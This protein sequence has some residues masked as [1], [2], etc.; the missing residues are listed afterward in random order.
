MEEMVHR[1][2]AVA[3]GAPGRVLVG[4]MPFDA[5]HAA[6][7][8]A[9]HNAAA[10]LKA[11]MNAVKVE[12]GGRM[13]GLVAHLVERGIPVMGHL[14]LTP[15]FVNAFGGMRGHGRTGDDPRP[16]L[17]DTLAPQDPRASPLLLP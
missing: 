5:Y 10:F 13:I 16:L 2:R 8:E 14:G 4:D 9:V 12:G 6:D 17:D 7:A 11:G 3:R 1:A 15:Q